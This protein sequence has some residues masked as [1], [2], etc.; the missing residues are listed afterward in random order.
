MKLIVLYF[1]FLLVTTSSLGNRNVVLF[2][3]DDLRPLLGC[4]G[5]FL[6]NTPNIDGIAKRGVVFTRAYTQVS[7]ESCCFDSS[8]KLNLMLLLYNL[9]K[10]FVHRVETHF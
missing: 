5:D 8:K 1:S 4:Y 3:V 2:I 7:R 10:H 6:A 9:S